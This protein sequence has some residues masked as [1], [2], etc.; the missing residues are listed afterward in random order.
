MFLTYGFL[1][2]G[3]SHLVFNLLTL[4]SLGRPLVEELGQ[5]RFLLLYLVAQLGGGAGYALLATQPAPMV[6]ASG[7]LFGLAGALVWMRLREGLR[8]MSPTEALRD[9]AWPVALL[10]GMN[11]VMYVALDGQLAWETHLGG[12]LAGAAAMAVLWRRPEAGAR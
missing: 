7:A 11:V 4:I 2:A 10:I 6:G 8:E 12:F 3:L 5:G 1:H 9:I